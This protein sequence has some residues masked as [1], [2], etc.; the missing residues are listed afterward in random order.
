[1]GLRFNLPDSQ[2]HNAGTREHLHRL[3]WSAYLLDYQCATISSQAV[4]VSD[5]EIHVDLPNEMHPS[6][7]HATDFQNTDSLVARLSLAKLANKIVRTIYGR[8]AYINP[9]LYRVQST[10][11]ELQH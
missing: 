7:T 4:S 8:G 10:L 6:E 9:F 11:K 3:W 5:D 2:V 1:M